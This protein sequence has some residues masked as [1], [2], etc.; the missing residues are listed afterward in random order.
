MSKHRTLDEKAMTVA[1]EA[2]LG[3]FCTRCRCHRSVE[4]GRLLKAGSGRTRWVCA[5]CLKIINGHKQTMFQE[6]AT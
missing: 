1:Q 4:G 3:K 5:T 6:K 2:I